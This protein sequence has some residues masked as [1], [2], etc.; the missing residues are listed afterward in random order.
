MKRLKKLWEKLKSIE[1][2]IVT[3]PP[4]W[5]IRRIIREAEEESKKSK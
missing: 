3:L 4:P 5:V 2:E 1:I